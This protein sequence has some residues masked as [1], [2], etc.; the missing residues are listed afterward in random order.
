VPTSVAVSVGNSFSWVES[1]KQKIQNAKN[2]NQD[3]FLISQNLENT[4]VIG[5]TKG[6]RQE[7]N[8]QFVKYFK[9]LR[10]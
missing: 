6:L 8:G 4:G 7:P 10:Y 3:I 5:L 1:I 2:D 9:I